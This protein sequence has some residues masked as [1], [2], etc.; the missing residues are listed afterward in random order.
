VA[1]LNVITEFDTFEKDFE[2]MTEAFGPLENSKIPIGFITSNCN[3]DFQS[4]GQILRN[5]QKLRFYTC[6]LETQDLPT[7]ELQADQ[8]LRTCND[9]RSLARKANIIA[10]IMCVVPYGSYGLMPNK[11]PGSLDGFQRFWC[12]IVQELKNNP[13]QTPIIFQSAFDDTPKR[14]GRESHEETCNSVFHRGWWR[15][16]SKILNSAAVF[17]EK[18]D[19][20]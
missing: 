11:I 19:C 12:R 15:R 8:I 14:Y 5:M 1:G 2:L 16:T 13:K 17:A 6:I 3:S 7:P 20:M 18:V 9:L 10:E 4:K